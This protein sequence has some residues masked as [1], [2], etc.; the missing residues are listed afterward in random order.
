MTMKHLRTMALAGTF[1][2]GTAALA[3]A[4]G[5]GGGSGGGSGS[6]SHT[7]TTTSPSTT[8]PTTNSPTT[9]SSST[10]NSNP[11][12][13]TGLENAEDRGNTKGRKMKR[14]GKAFQREDKDENER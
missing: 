8:S 12:G 3:F 14:H 10:M 4:A 9:N 5:T 6:G 1:V 11:T 7:T 2:L 13:N